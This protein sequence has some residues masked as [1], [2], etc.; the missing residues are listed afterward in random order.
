MTVRLIKY[1][2]VPNC[3]SYEVRFSDGRPSQFSISMTS[4]DDASGRTSSRALLE[5][6]KTYAHTERDKLV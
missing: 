1:E 6:A 5:Q 4:P 2:V 3:G